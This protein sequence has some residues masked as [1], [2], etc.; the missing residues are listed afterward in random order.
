MTQ[1][2]ITIPNFDEMIEE[3]VRDFVQNFD[4]DFI[5]DEMPTRDDVWE[6]ASDVINDH[7]HGNSGEVDIYELNSMLAQVTDGR[8]CSDGEPFRKAVKAII[9]AQ[10]LSNGNGVSDGTPMTLKVSG[11]ERE[12]QA[13]LTRRKEYFEALAHSIYETFGFGP[14]HTSGP[15]DH[16]DRNEWTDERERST[17]ESKNE[18]NERALSSTETVTLNKRLYDA[19]KQQHARLAGLASNA[20][21]LLGLLS[22]LQK[23]NKGE[24]AL[25]HANRWTNAANYALANQVTIPES[26]DTNDETTTNED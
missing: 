20:I 9:N 22:S 26:I 5:T 19:Y 2:E 17:D 11:E 13:I 18:L 25:R 1:V 12:I 7:D 24:A 10:A 3:V 4:F 8:D 16:E 21:N 23:G 15:E 14:G 6:I